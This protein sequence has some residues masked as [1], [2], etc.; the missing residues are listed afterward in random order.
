MVQGSYLPPHL[1]VLLR[2]HQGEGKPLAAPLRGAEDE[3]AA[4]PL[5]TAMTKFVRLNPT[6]GA[7]SGGSGYGLGQREGLSTSLSASS[8]SLLMRTVGEG[9]FPRRMVPLTLKGAETEI[10]KAGGSQE[11]GRWEGGRREGKGERQEGKA[12]L[13]C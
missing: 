7:K 8:S 4:R 6:G 2:G 9:R 10:C 11:G 1:V 5:A 12:D 3:A 13:T